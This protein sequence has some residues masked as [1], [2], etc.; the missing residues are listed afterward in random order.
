[1]VLL[2]LLTA[3]LEHALIREEC[4]ANAPNFP[5]MPFAATSRTCGGIDGFNWIGMEL[6]FQQ[7]V[8]SHSF[9]TLKAACS[10]HK[11][12]CKRRLALLV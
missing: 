12:D 10:Q 1:M 4:E 3:G 11:L 5:R 9:R 2:G 6:N 8:E 7:L